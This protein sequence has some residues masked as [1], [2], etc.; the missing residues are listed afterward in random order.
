VKLTV[1]GDFNCPLS[2]AASARVDV[3]HEQRFAAVEW[4]A[5]QHDPTIPTGGCRVTT[6]LAEAMTRQIAVAKGRLRASESLSLRLPPFQSNAAAATVA[7]ANA[8]A[9]TSN[10]VRRLLFRAIWA[11]GRNVSDPAEV[12]RITRIPPAGTTD[13][14][15]YWRRSWLGLDRLEVPILLLHTGYVARGLVALACLGRLAFTGALPYRPWAEF[16]TDILNGSRLDDLGA[17]PN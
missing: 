16:R 17:P 10:E 12:A 2:Y 5:V 6:Q 9:E 14:V 7:Y 11:V 4:R 3:I 8:P 1:Y 13:R 15:A